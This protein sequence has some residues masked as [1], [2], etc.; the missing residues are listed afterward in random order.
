ME[1]IRCFYSVKKH[2]KQIDASTVANSARNVVMRLAGDAID[3]P[4]IKAL[5]NSI[6]YKIRNLICY[7]VH[8]S[9]GDSLDESV[10]DS[11]YYL[12]Y[13]GCVIR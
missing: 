3:N 7:E 5:N 12:V 1:F 6:M 4:L 2:F 11:V 10:Y 9:V 8:G 13:M